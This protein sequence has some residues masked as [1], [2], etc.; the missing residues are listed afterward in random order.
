MLQEQESG[1]GAV[2]TVTDETFAEV[3]LANSRPV[4][5]D[6]W[7]SWCRPCVA[8]SKSLGELAEELGDQLVVAKLNSDDNPETTREY[9]VMALPT[10]L[11]FR[12]GEVV[13]TIVG[14]KPKAQLRTALT[15]VL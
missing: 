13:G 9:G 1:T 5:V 7:A 3:V 4:V 11:V 10:L 14:A 15:D 2:L 6:F 8:I 12:Q